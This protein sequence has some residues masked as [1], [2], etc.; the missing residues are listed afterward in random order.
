MPQSSIQLDER[1]RK[2]L[3]TAR[4]ERGLSR[5]QLATL[6]GLSS[7]TIARIEWGVKSPSE[8]SLESICQQIGLTWHQQPVVIYPRIKSDPRQRKRKARA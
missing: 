1:A 6:T 8:S 3:T 2:Q 5:A 4:E 7:N